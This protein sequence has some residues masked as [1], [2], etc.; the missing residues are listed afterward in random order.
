MA[1]NT[2]NTG[3]VDILL[4]KTLEIAVDA[5][6]KKLGTS[7]TWDRVGD[8]IGVVIEEH[9]PK[10]AVRIPNEARAIAKLMGF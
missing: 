4:N 3:R 9:V 6:D 10:K 7:G 8:A 2:G 5:L 1:K